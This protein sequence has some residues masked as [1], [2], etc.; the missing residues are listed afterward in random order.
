MK[1]KFLAP[2]MAIA[3]TAAMFTGAIDVYAE[4]GENNETVA[5][6]N[7]ITVTKDATI[8]HVNVSIDGAVPTQIYA[9]NIDGYNYF[10]L[11]DIAKP[12]N[13]EVGFSSV[14]A[15]SSPIVSI[16]PGNPYGDVV[17]DAPITTAKVRVEVT[18]AQSLSYDGIQSTVLAFNLGGYNYF[19]LADIQKAANESVIRH[20]ASIQ[21]LAER[22]HNVREINAPDIKLS[23]DEKTN[24]I[25]ITKIAI[26]YRA[27]YIAAGG[28]YMP[29]GQLMAS[30]AQTPIVPTSTVIPQTSTPVSAAQTA[31][32]EQYR[33]EM[34]K[35][36]NEARRSAGLGDV[37]IDARLTVMAQ[38]AVE[39]WTKGTAPTGTG[40]TNLAAEVG[41]SGFRTGWITSGSQTPQYSLNR[42]LQKDSVTRT[43][44]LYE[45]T[46]QV[47]YAH[48][49]TYAILITGHPALAAPTPQS[50]P[51]P[52]VHQSAPTSVADGR[53]HDG[54]PELTGPPTVGSFPAKILIDSSKGAY[55]SDGTVNR[56]NIAG[57]YNDDGY[58]S[59]GFFGQCTW[60]ACGRFTE[61][62]GIKAPNSTYDF[63]TIKNKEF[64]N[65]N[66]DKNA[67]TARSIAVWNGHYLFVE[68]VE[69][70]SN[71]NPT[72]V[73]F[74]EANVG[75]N[76]IYTPS[77]DGMVKKVTFK[78]FLTMDSRAFIGYISA[79]H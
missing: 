27:I 10:R 65:I 51:M 34:L 64:Y 14:S 44:V 31:T 66:T 49:G 21:A 32:E 9:Y 60:Y 18:D 3:V 23:Y 70:D 48:N 77:Q 20:T 57:T 67:I 73:Y 2:L 54:L 75:T 79:K 37:F 7:R 15:G 62:T 78:D 8:N 50:N 63:S 5:N 69:R 17:S 36:L 11:R 61:V 13:F 26:D 1:K 4:K 47:G 68:Y 22:G 38:I 39:D 71:G 53:I 46:T 16:T 76:G 59:A 12:L 41:Y 33:A 30:A 55:N 45:D 35:L 40:F 52:V 25:I 6:L 19:K 56:S 29:D 72:H 74:T 42:W 24:T 28:K 58:I 43:I